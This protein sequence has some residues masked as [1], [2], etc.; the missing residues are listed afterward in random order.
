LEVRRTVNAH[1]SSMHS[2]AY[3]VNCN[4]WHG[5]EW[6]DHAVARRT[7]GQLSSWPETAANASA[8]A[9]AAAPKRA[10]LP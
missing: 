5:S 10:T 1:T 2:R 4:Q 8:A 6:T 3:A 9:L 7:D